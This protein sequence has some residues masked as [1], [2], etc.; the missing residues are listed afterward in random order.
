V[1]SFFKRLKK[2]SDSEIDAKLGELIK[3][4]DCLQ[5]SQARLREDIRQIVREELKSTLNERNKKGW[6]QIA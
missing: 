4:I 5:S 6:E 2:S 1:N 3:R